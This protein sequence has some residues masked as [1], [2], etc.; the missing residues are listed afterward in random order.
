MTATGV[1]THRGG[2]VALGALEG[3]R[4]SSGKPET[5]RQAW[6]LWK[7]GCVNNPVK[8]CLCVCDTCRFT[9]M[10]VSVCECVSC[11]WTEGIGS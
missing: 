1:Q 8:T 3:G 9:C 6:S 11:M 2:L 10:R 4:E 5:R 7:C